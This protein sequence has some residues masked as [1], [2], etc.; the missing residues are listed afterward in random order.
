M[1]LFGSTH[2][3]CTAQPHRGQSWRVHFQRSTPTGY[4]PRGLNQ[5][6]QMVCPGST[7]EAGA[8]GPHRVGA[9]GRRE[10]AP[11]LITLTRP[12]NST[13]VSDGAASDSAVTLWP[14][15]R[16]QTTFCCG[17]P[18]RLFPFLTLFSLQVHL[19][20]PP[21]LPISVCIWRIGCYVANPR[22]S[23]PSVASLPCRSATEERVC[24]T[25]VGPLQL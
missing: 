6:C 14:P 3:S 16:A 7:D 2:V 4:F 24:S 22:N 25:S 8:G 18:P 17:V 19:R 20:D 5:R 15:G 1:S 21:T 10:Q 11:D 13:P 12:T 23:L 9:A